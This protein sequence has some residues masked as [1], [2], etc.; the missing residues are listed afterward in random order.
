M[1]G[2][3]VATMIDNVAIYGDD[4]A[5]FVK[6]VQTFLDRCKKVGATLNDQEKIPSTPD[7]ILKTGS[8]KPQTF[9][10][11]VYL[12]DGSVQ[13]TQSNVDKLRL[14]YERLQ[15][16][17][18]DS[19]VVVTKRNVLSLIG[20]WTWVSHTIQ[21]PLN[22]SF[23]V[24][25]LH[26]TI[27]SSL[28]EWDDPIKLSPTE[29]TAIGNAI[30][31]VLCNH[32][33]RPM[34]AVA[35]SD[36]HKDYAATIVVDASRSGYGALALINDRVVE[37]KGGFYKEMP[38]SAHAE[39]LAATI[40]LDWI[41]TKVHGPIAVITDHIALAQS[42]KRPCTGNG[43]FAK[44]YYLNSFLKDLYSDGLDHQVFYIPGDQNPA[45]GASRSNKIGDPISVTL[46]P[47]TIFPNLASL[48]HPFREPRKRPW[49][50]V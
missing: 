16:S 41:R 34:P 25:R 12:Q 15:A 36:D 19:E 6:A 45:D 14:A 46:R 30:A 7:E 13:N 43:G 35:P 10:G 4:A 23:D 33:H 47:S 37:V 20:L 1:K 28:G 8:C 22:K 21:H 38:H 31:P 48:Y 5:A 17:L 44:S 39:P 3:K 2:V 27:A 24:L 9:L 18:T 29:V 50:C 26:S 42:Q 32:P 49:W 11:E 40:L